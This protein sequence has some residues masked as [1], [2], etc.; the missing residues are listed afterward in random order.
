MM[1]DI[2]NVLVNFVSLYCVEDFASVFISDIAL[3]FAHCVVSL[4]GF[5]I[6]MTVATQIELGSLLPSASFWNS[7]RSIGVTFPL[8][9]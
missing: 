3:C 6:I 4:S 2:F 8:N 1:S 9:D 5:G 7:F